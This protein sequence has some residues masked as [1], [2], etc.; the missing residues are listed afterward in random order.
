MALRSVPVLGKFPDRS[1][2]AQAL[3]NYLRHTVKHYGCLQSD[4]WRSQAFLK[5]L[6]PYPKPS[7][8]DRLF[9][10]YERRL[11]PVVSRLRENSRPDGAPS[12]MPLASVETN[13]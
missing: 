11:A 12:G 7:L 3:P 8:T 1:D 10:R 5:P 9:M 2:V 6:K 13:A 4:A